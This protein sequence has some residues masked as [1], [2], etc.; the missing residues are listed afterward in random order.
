MPKSSFG[1]KDENS[2]I[3][4]CGSSIGGASETP[5]GANIQFC[6]NFQKTV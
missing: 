2:H 6:Q 3:S 1:V 5:G 4:H